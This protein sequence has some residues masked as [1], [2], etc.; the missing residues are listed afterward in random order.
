[1]EKKSC[2]KSAQ[3]GFISFRNISVVWRR[4]SIGVFS[5]VLVSILPNSYRKKFMKCTLF[6]QQVHSYMFY[7]H[8]WDF[9][10][11]SLYFIFLQKK[12]WF[13]CLF[14]LCCMYNVHTYILLSPAYQTCMQVYRFFKFFPALQADFPSCRII[15]F[16]IFYLPAGLIGMISPLQV[17]KYQSR[18]M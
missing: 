5:F 3:A 15:E 11:T 2:R 14:N 13:Q 8:Q 18:A 17:Y 12:N 16:T 10:T 6:M 7:K 4:I 9:S 1:M